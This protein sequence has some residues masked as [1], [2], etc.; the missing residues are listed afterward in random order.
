MSGM[1]ELKDFVSV[2]FDGVDVD[3]H[4]LGSRCEWLYDI[5]PVVLE[6]LR[7][8]PRPLSLRFLSLIVDDSH[9]LS[10]LQDFQLQ[11]VEGFQDLSSW[12]KGCILVPYVSDSK[13]LIESEES[14]KGSMFHVSG[15]KFFQVCKPYDDPLFGSMVLCRDDVDYKYMAPCEDVYEIDRDDL[16]ILEVFNFCIAFRRWIA[17]RVGVGICRGKVSWKIDLDLFKESVCSCGLY[18]DASLGTMSI[19]AHIALEALW[20]EIGVFGVERRDYGFIGGDEWYV[21]SFV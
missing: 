10:M 7:S 14:F 20:R 11:V 9:D 17:S 15:F 1:K 12:G 3:A 5:S 6:M 13:I 8:L 2:H 16:E 18:G 21:S 4:G 19:D